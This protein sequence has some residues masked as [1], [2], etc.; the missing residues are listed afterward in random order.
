MCEDMDLES[1]KV[2]LFT[3]SSIP[4]MLGKCDL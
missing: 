2:R 3:V 4:I 1:S